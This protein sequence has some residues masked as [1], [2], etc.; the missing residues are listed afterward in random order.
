MDQV[1][2]PLRPPR[3]ADGMA[4]FGQ[5]GQDR[6]SQDRSDQDGSGDAWRR[7]PR[8]IGLALLLAVPVWAGVAALVLAR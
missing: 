1:V 6:G 3:P 5:A 8:G 4:A 7:L 2:I